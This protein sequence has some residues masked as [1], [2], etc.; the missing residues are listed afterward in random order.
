MT[1]FSWK[2][3][4]EMKKTI[5]AENF[6]ILEKPNEG[7]LVTFLKQQKG[8]EFNENHYQYKH[9]K[10]ENTLMQNYYDKA[11]DEGT[12]LFKVK[13]A[14][15]KH[16]WGRVA[17]K[18]Y[19]SL[20]VM[21]RPTRHT[22][23]DGI[24]LDIDIVNSSQKIF[25]EICLLHEYNNIIRLQEYC[26]NRKL[27]FKKMMEIFNTS[28]QICKQFF[29]TASFGGSVETWKKKYKLNGNWDWL[30]EYQ[31]QL[32]QIM[33]IVWLHNQHIIDD[34]LKVE[35][36]K[37]KKYKTEK[38]IVSAKKRTCMA[39]FYQTVERNIQ[40]TMINFLV[41]KKEFDLHYIIPCQDG[42]MI[43][44]ELWY[45]EI[46]N[47][48]ENVV[49][50]KFGFNLQLKQK[51][52]D[53]K[54]ELIPSPIRDWKELLDCKGIADEIK[55][56][57]GKYIKHEKKNLYVFFSEIRNEKKECVNGKWYIDEEASK[58]LNRIIT[59]WIY[60]DLKKEIVSEVLQKKKQTKF[61]EKVRMS[62]VDSTG[63]IEKHTISIVD[64]PTIPFD[65]N[66]FLLGF[67]NGVY[68]L[69]EYKFV[70][71]EPEFYI[72]MT[73]CYD[74]E[75]LDDSEE[76][77]ILKEDFCKFLESIMPDNSHSILLLKILASGLDGLL[78]QK[79][80]ML[81]GGG[82]NGKGTIIDLL[83]LVLGEY[84]TKPTASLLSD[85]Q[86][87]NGASEDLYNLKGKRF[88]AFEECNE[89]INSS[90][91]RR[92]TGG[93]KMTARK[94]FK[95]VEEFTLN[96]TI[97]ALLNG[98]L[99]IDISDNERPAFSRRLVDL[100]F[101]RNFTSNKNKIGTK[102]QRKGYE[103]LFMEESPKYQTD[104]WRNQMKLI[105]LDMLIGVHK[106]YSNKINK[107]GID[108]SDIPEDVVR[109]T[110]KFMDDKNIFSKL[111]TKYIRPYKRNEDENMKLK[112]VW[113]KIK[114][115]EDYKKAINKSDKNKEQYSYNALR[116][117]LKNKYGQ[118]CIDKDTNGVLILKGFHLLNDEEEDSEDD[119]GDIN[120]KEK[121][122]D[123][124]DSDESTDGDNNSEN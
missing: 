16:K 20:A 12:E 58:R 85:I 41:E 64:N 99:D 83:M 30:E 14:L 8:I 90:N 73:C 121:K 93:G 89:F 114:F 74:F 118:E 60:N 6:V 57:Y 24:Y 52:F 3:K 55:R 82:G 25:L 112:S 109:N 48:C 106:E 19:T 33:D 36:D 28:E 4:E 66:P 92:L 53:E 79:F 7:Q 18:G 63:R 50:N 80:F 77:E 76:T 75:E 71:N 45:E 115:N 91:L 61:L 100:F 23:C 21:H 116:T 117:F 17:P 98:Y 68:D 26:D 29:I 10:N 124:D 39:I 31:T 105:F 81:N 78:Y 51:E 84:A 43:L 120:K 86:K 119:D 56:K 101:T 13:V 46:L 34:I 49:L 95:S 113:D 22:L 35:P 122:V 108:F 87:A 15:P 88:L 11:Y 62:C 70:S 47:D 110:E 9:F 27:I 37:Y 103:V 72:T 94:L 97:C 65:S 38:D 111:L 107:T 96:S 40:E 32:Y 104:E 123:D 67:N 42:F 5:Y 102:E 54:F 69:L 59:E 1:N 2:L 44:K